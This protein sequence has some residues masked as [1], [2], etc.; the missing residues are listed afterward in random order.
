VFLTIN[1]N[2]FFLFL[3]GIVL[4]A[5]GDVEVVRL[6]LGERLSDLVL[7]LD[8]LGVGRHRPM[9]LVPEDVELQERRKKNRRHDDQGDEDLTPEYI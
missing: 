7:A 8:G 4:V 3:N 5:G 1:C 2:C 6:L 9:G